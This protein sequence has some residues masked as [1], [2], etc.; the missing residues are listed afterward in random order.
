MSLHPHLSVPPPQEL[1]FPHVITIRTFN[2]PRNPTIQYRQ[3]AITSAT[4]RI[5]HARHL[6]LRNNGQHLIH[7]SASSN[8]KTI[9]WAAYR[10]QSGQISDANTART[11][12]VRRKIVRDRV[13]MRQIALRMAL[14]QFPACSAQNA[15]CIIAWEIRKVKVRIIRVRVPGKVVVLKGKKLKNL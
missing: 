5:R 12:I 4:F 3:F 14:R 13:N 1:P 6:V 15:W 7:R 2:W 10:R 9:I 8:S 11:F